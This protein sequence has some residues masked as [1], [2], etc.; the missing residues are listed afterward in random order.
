L[1]KAGFDKTRVD[2]LHRV[3]PLAA[4]QIAISGQR[5]PTFWHAVRDAGRDL[6]KLN[7][8]PVDI[9]A[10]LR[11]YDDAIDRVPG[12]DSLVVEREQL[13]CATLLAINQA[14][15]EFRQH[16]HQAFHRMLQIEVESSNIDVLLRRLLESVAAACGSEA[17]HAY[18]LAGDGEYWEI[19]ASTARAASQQTRAR[20]PASA[21]SKKALANPRLATKS[22]DTLDP[23]WRE[24]YRVCWSVPVGEEGVLQFAFPAGRVLLPRE[25]EMLSIAGERCCG[26][27]RKARMM[28]EIA[29][30]EEQ[31]SKLAIRMLMV[32][33]NERRR[34]SRELHDDAGQSLVVIRLQMELIEQLLPEGSEERERLAEARDITEKT[35][36][37]IR[38]LISDLSP[39]V[40]QQ[41]GLGAA[42]RQLANRFRGRYPCKLTLVVDPLPDLH[43]TFQLVI[44]RLTQEC[45]NNISQ[46]S[47]ATTVNISVSAADRVLRLYVEDNGNGFDVESVLQ[48][49]NS[50]G[51]VGIRERVAVLGGSV[52]FIS[53]RKEGHSARRG[54]KS[55]SIVRIELP[56]S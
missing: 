48:S 28:E 22:T 46:H 2:V 24:Q 11:T 44:Y 8:T 23:G 20:V 9:T 47:G 35:I 7:V 50:F 55:G 51:L 37:D 12:S 16:E 33:E 31:L 32:E 43:P 1:R 5:L 39:A 41:L 26:A 52:D 15:H 56:I 40:L 27:V 17:A 38:R 30:R 53:T 21:A 14:Y 3:S 25:I 49:A 13:R 54:K 6:A 18:L 10:A 34:I 42:L 4:A 45:L 29:L 19:A 36:L